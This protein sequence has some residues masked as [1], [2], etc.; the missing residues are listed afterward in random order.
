M[1]SII[2]A[3]NAKQFDAIVFSEVLEHLDKPEKALRSL[4]YLC[5][6]GG[7]VW[8]NVPA[9]S[10]AP[11]HLYLV[12]EPKQA[13]DAVRAAGFEVVDTAH[14]PMTGITLERAIRQQLTITCIIVGRRPF[15]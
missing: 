6:P 3:P 9:N 12:R 1:T 7:R 14:L 13:E 10:P 11:D 8:I 2:H 15:A 5:K 4:L